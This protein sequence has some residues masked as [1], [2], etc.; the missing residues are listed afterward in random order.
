MKEYDEQIMLPRERD[1]LFEEVEP[2]DLR[3]EPIR[4]Y[5]EAEGKDRSFTERH[6]PITPA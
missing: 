1:H 5:S 3:A 2:D 6:T 4:R